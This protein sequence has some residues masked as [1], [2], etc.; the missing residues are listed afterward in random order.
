[1]AAT[2]TRPQPLPAD[3]RLMNAVA[4]AVFAL[5]ALAVL[6]VAASWIARQPY[7][8]LRTV[9]VDGEFARSTEPTLRSAVGTSVQGNFFGIELGAV[10]AAF[11]SVPWVRQAVVR[12]IWPDRLR[13]TLVEHRAVALWT[14]AG[15][16]RLVNDFGE[17]F[18]AN[19]GDV[20]DEGLPRFDGPPDQSARMLDL[21]R[22]LAPV[23]AALPGRIETLHLS[24]RGS[25]RVELDSGA[26]IE[27][28]RGGA[29]DE[30]LEVVARAQRFVRTV[31]EV[32]AQYQR[33]LLHAD[34]RHTDGYAV[35]LEG[36]TT[37]ADTAPQ[38]ATR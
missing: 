9:V 12:R 4:Y 3:V 36:I 29:G 37:T 1:M 14:A 26:V 30:A 28:G 24:R 23:L 35:R 27:L 16:D 19:V 11:E 33:R 10:R 34:L 32:T 15:E 8:A 21:Y 5:A 2:A 18:E 25:W 13:V 17:V 20:E 7:F 31:G 38:R 22:Q 6:A